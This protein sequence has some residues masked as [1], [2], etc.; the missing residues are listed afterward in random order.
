MQIFVKTLT[1]KTITLDVD[2]SDTTE[3]VIKHTIQGKEGTPR[4]TDQQRLCIVYPACRRRL[5]E[6]GRTL[7]NYGTTNEAK[8]ELVGL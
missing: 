6:D 2:A 1:G 3:C 4:A 5:D 8:L 7:S